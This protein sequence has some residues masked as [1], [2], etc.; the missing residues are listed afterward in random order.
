MRAPVVNYRNFRLNK[1]NDP[2]FS[3]LWFLLGWVLH[4]VLYMFTEQLTPA[5]ECHPVHMWLDDVIPFCEWFVIPYVLWYLFLAATTV[6][7]ALYNPQ[8]LKRFMSYIIIVMVISSI[9]YVVYPTRQDL[10]PAVF[11]RENFCTWILGTLYGAD[12]STGVCPSQHV[13]YSVAMAAVWCREPSAKRWQKAF[14][15]AFAVLIAASTCFVKQH[16]AVDTFAALPVCLVAELAV[17]GRSYWLP[18]FK[19]IKN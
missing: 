1:L 7:F 12:T 4:F 5:A 13:G 14:M 3:H 10:R 11:E 18:K 15:V 6:Y 9:I 8:N 16:S 19:R 2:E 17:F